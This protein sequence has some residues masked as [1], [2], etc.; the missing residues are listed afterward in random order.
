VH[1]AGLEAAMKVKLARPDR[2]KIDMSE[3]VAVRYWCKHFGITRPQL[4]N[5]IDK[6]GHSAAA[7]EKELGIH[8]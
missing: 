2:G 4:Q 8:D 6:V 7:V 5:I 1:A 3:D